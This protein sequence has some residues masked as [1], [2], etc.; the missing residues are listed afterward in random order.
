[1]Q[2]YQQLADSNALAH[3]YQFKYTFSVVI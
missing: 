1:L 2:L 3:V